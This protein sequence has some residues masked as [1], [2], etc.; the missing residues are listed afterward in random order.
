MPK[1]Q[2]LESH[3]GLGISRAWIAANEIS[4]HVEVLPT[5]ALRFKQAS[6]HLVYRTYKNLMLNSGIHACHVYYS[7]SPSLDLSSAESPSL[8]LYFHGF[9]SENHRVVDPELAA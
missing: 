9:T 6:G 8:A 5:P 3:L 4:V 2:F 1:I 7:T